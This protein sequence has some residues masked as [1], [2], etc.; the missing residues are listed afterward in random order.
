MLSVVNVW[1][2]QKP[3]QE[4]H[5]PFHSLHDMLSPFSHF[6]VQYGVVPRSNL[7]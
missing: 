1:E 2:N 7:V 6:G 5:V 3:S 4:L